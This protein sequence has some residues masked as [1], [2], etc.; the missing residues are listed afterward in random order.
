MTLRQPSRSLRTVVVA[1]AIVLASCGPSIG[2]SFDDATIVA[3]VKTALLNDLQVGRWGIE[4]TSS[5]GFVRL[6]GRVAT[7]GDAARA[8]QIARNVDG[9]LDV[10]SMI[11]IIP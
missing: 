9:V 3:R 8:V 6:S 2:D 4:A 1:V 10:T 11:Q 7:D 5:R